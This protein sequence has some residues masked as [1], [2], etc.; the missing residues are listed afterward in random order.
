MRASRR[1]RF[2][3][4]FFFTGLHDEYHAPNDTADTL[5]P[6]GAARIIDLGQRVVLACAT[7]AEKFEFN[8][9]G[10][11]EQGAA[12]GDGPSRPRMRVRFGIQPGDYAGEDGVMVGG[13]T[14]GGTAAEAGV[15]KD[16]RIVKWNG[17]DVT[18]V[19][20]WM[21]LMGGHRPGDEVEFV[22]VREGKEV[23]LKAK[24]KSARQGNQ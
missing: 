23:Q 22:V 10:A 9:E 24:M 7:R 2:P 21:E 20:S 15:Q 17:K 18:T 6:A 14:E 8:S 16:D 3:S 13:V 12:T 19:R 1:C 11:S 4:C 5:N